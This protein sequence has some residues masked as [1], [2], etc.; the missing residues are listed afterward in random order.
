MQLTLE[1]QSQ[2]DLQLILQYVRLLPR[3]KVLKTPAD[4]AE[5]QRSKETEAVRAF[6]AESDAF[7][8]WESEEEDIYQ[9]FLPAAA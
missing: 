5:Q 7:G 9:D 1:I 6:A 4:D 2:N 8:F 3:V